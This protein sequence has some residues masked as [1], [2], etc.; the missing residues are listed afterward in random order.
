MINKDWEPADEPWGASPSQPMRSAPVQQTLTPRS[1]GGLS[2]ALTILLWTSCGLAVLAVVDSIASLQWLSGKPPNGADFWFDQ[3]AMWAML[4]GLL[5]FLAL[6][7]WL[8]TLV[9]RHA[10]QLPRDP[11][12]HAC[13]ACA[14]RAAHRLV[15]GRLA[16]QRCR[17]A[18]LQPTLLRCPDQLRVDRRL[19]VGRHIS[20][21]RSSLSCAR[22]PGRFPRGRT[23][24]GAAEEP[25]SRSLR[26]GAQPLT[27]FAR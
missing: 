16:P 13:R 2:T 20:T 11:P 7:V 17:W 27:G 18:D 22:H 12:R 24:A 25:R 19:H 9:G 4:S 14:L 6:A 8:A 5:A 23:A 26:N 15:V 10:T 21:D 3:P 1:I